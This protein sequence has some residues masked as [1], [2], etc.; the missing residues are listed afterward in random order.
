MNVN[1]PA[2]T[3]DAKRARLLAAAR[4]REEARA[5]KRA[6]AEVRR[7]ELVEQF[8]AELGPEGEKFAVHDATGIGEGFFV[9]KLGEPILFQRYLDSKM[10]PADRCDFVSQCIAYPEKDM[11]LAARGRRQGIDIELVN[12]L[13]ALN[14]VKLKNDEGK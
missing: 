14:G 2:E 11:Y 13:G 5:A 3:P 4:Q 1:T 6:E 7:L 9:V 12:L 10:T 8:E